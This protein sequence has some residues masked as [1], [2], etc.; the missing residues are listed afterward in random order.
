MKMREEEVVSSSVS[1][2]TCREL[3]SNGIIDK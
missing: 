1:R 3:D 2:I